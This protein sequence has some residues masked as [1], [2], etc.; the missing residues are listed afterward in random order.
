M[1][2]SL[3]M[4]STHSAEIH[5]LT[6]QSQG[7][8]ISLSCCSVSFYFLCVFTPFPPTSCDSQPLLNTDN[9]SLLFQHPYSAVSQT[10]NPVPAAPCSCA[11]S[12]HTEL[13]SS[14]M[15]LTDSKSSF[16]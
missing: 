13:K 5:P 1:F 14:N 15:F 4:F 8:E 7:S 11:P 16:C 3:N 9:A 12:V 10:S 2:K 6:V